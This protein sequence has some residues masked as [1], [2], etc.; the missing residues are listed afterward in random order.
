MT[1]TVITK[2]ERFESLVNT[3][4]RAYLVTLKKERLFIS[5]LKE[6]EIWDTC[7]GNTVEWHAKI[8]ALKR[9]LGK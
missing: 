2:N 9:L 8:E 3:W 5:R 1:D 4:E 7:N 6:L